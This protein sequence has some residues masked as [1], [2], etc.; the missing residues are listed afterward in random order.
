MDDIVVESLVK[1][2]GSVQ[3]VKG[4]SFTVGRGEVFGILGPNGAGK[5]TTL[6]CVEGLQPPTSGAMRV[7]GIDTHREPDRVKERIGVQL[8]ASAYFEHLTLTEILELFGRFYRR[9][10][11]AEELLAKV[12]LVEKAHTQVK[13]L[14]GGQQQRFAIAATLVN[15]PE[16]IFL[17]EPTTGLDPQ[18]RRN[19]W[20]FIERIHGEARTVVLTTHYMEEAQALCQRVAIMDRGEI[21]AMD[22]PTNLIR[23]L[24]APY[25]VRAVVPGASPGDEVRSLDGVTG[26]DLGDDGVLALQ[27]CD[28]TAT[29]R[30]LFEWGD[31]S[32]VRIEHL[33]VRPATLEDVFLALT[34][35]ALEA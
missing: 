28:S 29:V 11:P 30:A 8:Q 23:G 10:L 24:D 3:A 21:V 26:V 20:E 35:R 2:Y 14:S 6:E 16:V 5:T 7:L 19:L 27:S 15:D 9:S 13:H 18:A 32:N 25:Q 22:T 34:G 4:I 17:D 12:G 33:E 1:T 31:R